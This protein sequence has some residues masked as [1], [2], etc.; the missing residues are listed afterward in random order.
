[1]TTTFASNPA[2]NSATSY[3]Q[4]HSTQQ[5]SS[6]G[7][8][9]SGSRI[10]RASDDAASLSIGT[11][12]SANVAALK[13]AS[14]NTTHAQSMLQMADGG[15]SRIADALSRMKS[16]ATQANA[17]TMSTEEIGYLNAEYQQL[18]NQIDTIAEGTKFNGR[19]L[20]NGQMAQTVD[21]NSATNV[22]T[23]AFSLSVTQKV[24]TGDWKISASSASSS[25][26]NFKLTGPDSFSSVISNSTFNNS[27]AASGTIEFT[28]GF[29][30]AI[31]S[32]TASDFSSSNTIKIGN[33][34]E[35]NFQVGLDA[36]AGS[37]VI[38]VSGT[39]LGD[40]TAAGLGVGG[41]G[42]VEDLTG[43]LT[44]VQTN[45]DAAIKQVN[46]Q[47]SEI[48]SFMSR[49]ET[50]GSN[51]ATTIENLDAARS[52]LM[53]VDVAEEMTKFST[54]QV[55]AQA[56]TAMLAQANQ[57]PQNLMRLLQ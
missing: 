7:K 54:T 30:L 14:V 8:L 9:S 29:K 33:S 41:G 15:M 22:A 20:L 2:A 57:L 11:K 18:Q 10:V 12:M 35:T 48:G 21:T 28:N 4:R 5:S 26:V 44:T 56:A 46:D 17:G 50:V 43:D 47:R 24:A 32:W 37:D 1:M 38:G 3:L 13:Q 27:S 53:D 55:Q 49:F 25:G 31:S 34:G 52:T 39:A 36:S 23:G 6:I 42:G 40:A 45:L 19:S 16:L 51:L